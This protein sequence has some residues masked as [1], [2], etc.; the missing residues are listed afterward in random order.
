MTTVTSEL[1][2]PLESADFPETLTARVVTPGGCPRLHGYD[3]EN[4][5]ARHYDPSDVLFLSLTGELPAP[6][7][8]RALAVV[9]TFLA[10]LS[11]AHASVHAA[12]LARLC[13]TTT[14]S[15]IGVAAIVLA[16][17]ARSL[18]EE[19]AGLLTWLETGGEDLPL[20]FRSVDAEDVASCERLRAALAGVGFEVPEL[21]LDP[22]RCAALVSVLF[23]C[24]LSQ[25]AQLEAAIVAARLPTAVAEALSEKVVDFA[26]Y[27]TNL[28]RYHYTEPE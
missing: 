15:T 27:P 9:L 11:I 5:L 25:R 24:G 17:Q 13:G 28:P 23:R 22:T 8:S 19:H 20:R 3:V 6:N 21:L 4:D 2:G 16:E 18:L 10:P 1:R 12:S 14:S 7:V 26:N